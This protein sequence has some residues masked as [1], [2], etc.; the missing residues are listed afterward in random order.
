MIDQLYFQI[1]D[2]LHVTKS[3]F[4]CSYLN[5]YLGEK[6]LRKRGLK[7][8]DTIDIRKWKETK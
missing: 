3:T 1:I 7:E 4:Y 5:N 8:N 2:A 6:Y